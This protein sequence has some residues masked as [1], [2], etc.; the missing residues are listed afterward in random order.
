MAIYAIC[1]FHFSQSKQAEVWGYNWIEA[2]WK[3]DS[4]AYICVLGRPYIY[5]THNIIIH[6][7]SQYSSG[8]YQSTKSLTIVKSHRLRVKQILIRSTL[9][10]T[11]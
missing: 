8:G 1:G 6:I 10:Y 3:Y 5:Y 9:N 7:L 11:E 4:M 2:G